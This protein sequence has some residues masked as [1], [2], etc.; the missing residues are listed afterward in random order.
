M[1]LFFQNLF[2]C[3]N[4]ICFGYYFGGSELSFNEYYGVF[5]IF[6]SG[7]FVTIFYVGI[8][9]GL[10][11]ML[12]NIML[13]EIYSPFILDIANAFGP[14]VT[15]LLFRMMDLELVGVYTYLSFGF[16]VPGMILIL[17]G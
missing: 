1:N 9:L 8:M 5:G 17:S 2:I 4:Y 14:L 15:S 6:D 7:N 16:F 3:F 13:Y 12:S 10:N 11:L